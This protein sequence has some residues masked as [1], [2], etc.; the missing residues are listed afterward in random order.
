ME[1]PCAD[2]QWILW[3]MLFRYCN[4][5]ECDISIRFLNIKM[6]LKLFNFISVYHNI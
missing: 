6:H 3:H 1:G 4:L 5:E 2:C